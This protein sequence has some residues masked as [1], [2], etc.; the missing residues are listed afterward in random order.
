MNQ[1]YA[2]IPVACNVTPSAHL[3]E[4]DHNSLTLIAEFQISEL[5]M[6]NSEH[7]YSVI[8]YKT[9]EF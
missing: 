1:V 2:N 9:L 6:F 3:G 7:E 4:L 5:L 8:R